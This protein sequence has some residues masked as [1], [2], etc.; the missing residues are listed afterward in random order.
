[1]VKPNEL[2]PG[3]YY[4]V[5]FDEGTRYQEHYIVKAE[6]HDW[7]KILWNNGERKTNGRTGTIGSAN[8][9]RHITKAHA[10]AGHFIPF[11][12]EEALSFLQTGE[13]I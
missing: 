11:S 4:E 6:R 13:P 5:I 12:N 7:V 8:V 3:Y 9:I 10:M 2:T 1:M